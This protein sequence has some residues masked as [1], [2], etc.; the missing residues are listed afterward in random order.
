MGRYVRRRRRTYRTRGDYSISR[1]VVAFAQVI[2]GVIFLVYAIP[3]LLSA[4]LSQ[5]DGVIAL[6]T[7]P[8][9]LAVIGLVLV[10]WGSAAGKRQR[11]ARRS[12][13]MTALG[14]ATTLAA[15]MATTPQA[16]KRPP[17][18]VPSPVQTPAPPPGAAYT[19]VQ[20]EGCGAKNKV[21]KGA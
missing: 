6:P 13:G 12:A 5:R 9:A 2:F 7:L 19:L 16:P 18:T 4:L 21:I 11:R 14:L 8:T 15:S 10:I 20:C 3:A 17:P 1:V